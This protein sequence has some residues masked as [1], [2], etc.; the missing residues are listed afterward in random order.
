MALSDQLTDL[1]ARTRDLEEAAAATRAKNR[2]KLEDQREKLHS[3]IKTE[4][5]SILSTAGKAETGA[6]SW[7]T[8]TTTR[9][10]QQPA[11]TRPTTDEHRPARTGEHPE[12]DRAA[13]REP[14]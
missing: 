6:R 4:A 12:P 3:K 13:A 10:E 1:A 11:A 8:D 9:L 2:V 5:Q 7:L 14:A